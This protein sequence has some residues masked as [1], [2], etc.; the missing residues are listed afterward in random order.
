MQV[1]IE[2]LFDVLIYLDQKQVMHRDL[3]PDN[4]M[5]TRKQELKVIDFGLCEKKQASQ[6]AGTLGYM[7]PDVIFGKRGETYGT[8]VDVWSAGCIVFTALYGYCPF[9][10]AEHGVVDRFQRA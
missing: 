7:A 3:K 8:K 10:E 9:L 2:Q 6:M 4:I 1:I 5:I